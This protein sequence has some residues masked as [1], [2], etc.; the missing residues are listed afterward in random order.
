M[1]ENDV[2]FTRRCQHC[3]EKITGQTW[4]DLTRKYSEHVIE[5]HGKPAVSRGG[6]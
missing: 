1:P 3:R 6:R 2:S 4:T 5:E